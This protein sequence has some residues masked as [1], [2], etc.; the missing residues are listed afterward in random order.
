MRRERERERVKMEEPVL[1]CFKYLPVKFWFRSD[2]GFL[3]NFILKNSTF[4]FYDSLHSRKK[5]LEYFNASLRT[6]GRC[7]STWV[8]QAVLRV[9]I[10]FFL[11]CK[12]DSYAR[13]F[14]NKPIYYRFLFRVFYNRFHW[15]GRRILPFRP[16]C[17]INKHFL[18][19]DWV[20]V[21][22]MCT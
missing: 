4:H 5:F 2:N 8:F 10:I 12:V 9:E 19:A 13:C 7:P 1:R 3:M 20:S 21:T 14:Y 18:P 11:L 22:C 6:F 15:S 17:F 16:V